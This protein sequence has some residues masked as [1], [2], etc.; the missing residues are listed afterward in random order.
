MKKVVIIGGGASGLVAA[1]YAAKENNE[2]TILERNNT[3]GK[4]ILITGNG[5]CNYFNE[6]QNLNY[7]HSSEKHLLGK[8]ITPHNLS[9]VLGFFDEIGIVPKIKNGYY[10]PNSNQA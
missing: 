1:I 4:K 5:R 10:Y 9:E 7:Y 6:Y 3:V 2:V 8:I